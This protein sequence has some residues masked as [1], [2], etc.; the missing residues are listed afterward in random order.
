MRR[1]HQSRD[2]SKSSSWNKA[3]EEFFLSDRENVKVPIFLDFLHPFRRGPR[4]QTPNSLLGLLALS[5]YNSEL[6]VSAFRRSY[7]QTAA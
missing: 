7:L 1:N 6:Q 3:I 2:S 5:N 4:L